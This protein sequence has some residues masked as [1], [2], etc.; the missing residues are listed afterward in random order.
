VV[1]AGSLGLLV[2]AQLATAG[3]DR[4]HVVGLPSN[5][6]V[7]DAVNRE[8]GVRVANKGDAADTS[9]WVCAK[10]CCVWA[11][12]EEGS[13]VTTY[14]VASG[15]PARTTIIATSTSR[16]HHCESQCCH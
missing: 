9:R 1:G 3:L 6:D 16:E 7:L 4:V 5:A 8:G 10:S 11:T 14:H 15:M 12:G 2:A 13:F